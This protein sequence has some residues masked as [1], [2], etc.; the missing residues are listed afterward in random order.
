M[1]RSDWGIAP[2]GLVR[3]MGLVILLIAPHARLRADLIENNYLIQIANQV[4]SGCEAGQYGLFGSVYRT[5]CSLGGYSV[6]I[7]GS[8][9]AYAD[10]GLAETYSYLDVGGWA[11]EGASFSSAATAW[12]FDYWSNTSDQPVDVTVTVSLITSSDTWQTESAFNPYQYLEGLVSSSSACEGTESELFGGATSSCTISI[13][14]H[15]TY[16]VIFGART[17]ASVYADNIGAEVAGAAV[18]AARLTSVSVLDAN[19]NVL[20]PSI[21]ES[22]NGTSLTSAGYVNPGQLVDIASAPEP[23]TLVLLLAGGAPIL[24]RYLRRWHTCPERLDWRRQPRPA[25]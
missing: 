21:L 10:W 5:G 19:G 14:A 16:P 12:A 17:E 18:A 25:Q 9:S 4:G 24:S 2:R 11:G 6:P 13:G 1:R 20:P 7:A 22:S 8:G 23:S 3:V 15:Q